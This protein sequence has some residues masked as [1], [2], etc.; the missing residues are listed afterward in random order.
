MTHDDC[1][2]LG[3]ITKL[4]GYKGAM[5]MFLD[6]DD[7]SLYHELD[8]VFLDINGQLIPH[9]ITR[10]DPRGNQMI[11]EFQGVYGEAAAMALINKP[12]YLPLDL[13]PALSGKQFYF[14]EVIGFTIRDLKFGVV[15]TIRAITDHPV[16]PLF[17]VD[18]NE[19]E[20]LIPMND[21]VLVE[22]NRELRE[23][24]TDTPDG[25]IELFLGSGKEQNED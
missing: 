1:F 15:G 6:V 4:H 2:Y 18:H 17:I 20:V 13:L 16:N 23:I 12:I 21:D 8:G 22:V 25:L 5:V 19:R 24:V 10:A 11:V 14:H 3:K 9:F 7:P